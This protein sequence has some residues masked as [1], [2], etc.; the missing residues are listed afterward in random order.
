MSRM[1][2]GRS[3]PVP[4]EWKSA[5]Q[6]MQMGY[7]GGNRVI[8]RRMAALRAF[9]IAE[10]VAEGS[11]DEHAISHVESH[12]VGTKKPASGPST[13]YASPEAVDMLGLEH[14]DRPRSK[15]KTEQE[16]WQSGYKLSKEYR[17][18]S[19]TLARRLKELRETLRNDMILAGIDQGAA[20]AVIE[21][22]FV[23]DIQ[24]QF[25]NEPVTVASPEAIRLLA[26]QGIL[27]RK[28]S[29]RKGITSGG[30][31]KDRSR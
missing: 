14:R 11:T 29:K 17:S 18:N 15:A 3:P 6:L 20:E 21:Q 28:W 27:K 12:F 5:S 16:T 7:I 13:L 8:H 23:R 2:K 26:E 24:K 19:E 22:H 31:S 9:L 30:E 25:N 4:Q 1:D 10:A